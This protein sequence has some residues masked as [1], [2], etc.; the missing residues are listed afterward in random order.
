MTEGTLKIHSENIL[1]IIK[2]WM[3]SDRDIFVRELISNAC[4]AIHK[5][6]VL[7]GRGEID[8]KDEE[9]RIDLQID[10]DSNTLSFVDTGIGMTSEE[11]EKYIAQLAFSGA[12]EFLDKYSSSDSSSQIIGHFGL[13]F[14]SAYM[15]A[16]KV[17]IQTQSYQTSSSPAHWSC[18]GT[19]QYTLKEGA[20]E[21]RGTEIIL[22]VNEEN[23]EFLDENRLRGILRRYCSFLPYPIFLNGE[24][25]NSK[26]PL[27]VRSAN[28]LKDEDYLDFF[29]HLYP[30]EPD[31]LF[32][33]H[34][35]VDYPFHLQGILYFPKHTPNFEKQKDNIHLYCNRVFVSDNCKDLVPDFLLGLRGVLD[36]PDIP[37]NVSRSYLQM[38]RTVRQLSSH[39]SKKVSQRLHTLHETEKERYL[40]SWPNIE[41]IVKL[42]ALQDEKFYER[43][44][45]LILWKNLSGEW[46]NA[47]DYLERNREKTEGKIFYTT[48]EK[49]AEQFLALYQKREIE[50]LISG[51]LIDTM[52][53]SFLERKLEKAQF[54]RVDGGLDNALLDKEKENSI[55]DS[56][57]RTEA[58]RMED[59]FQSVLGKE[60]V[61]V[62]AKSL[63]SEELPGFVMIEEG[64]RRMRDYMMAMDPNGQGKDFQSLGQPQYIINTN[65][66]LVQSAYK[67]SKKH[68]EL[69]GEIVH[70]LYELSLLSQAELGAEDLNGFVKRSNQVM[71][72]LAEKLLKD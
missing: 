46:T 59:Y 58:S 10:K 38:D 13:G 28:E 19:S 57:G 39:I 32:W 11:V 49:R 47:E 8:V 70:N 1:P 29:H 61:K 56:E 4:D 18:D 50:V 12:E 2:K 25:I 65:N 36:S 69:S 64:M 21:S 16:D 72:H 48:Q 67:M 68:P 15:V 6:E 24:Q 14:Y 54:Q 31:P 9:F 35:N 23:Q 17:D 55:L 34:L 42:G 3:Y 66:S 71:E 52:L 51:A 44:K 27:W 40:E 33:I 22:H 41:V 37:L 53:I 7:R 45:H 60:K 62:E 63:A 20:R 30:G 26:Q 5:V 43:V